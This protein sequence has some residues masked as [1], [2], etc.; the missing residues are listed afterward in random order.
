MTAVAVLQAR[1]DSRRLP[2]KALLPIAGLPV[3][4][5]AARRAANRGLDLIVATSDEGSDDPLADVLREAG[6]TV[7]RGSR[8]DVLGRLAAAIGAVGDD[9]PVI[10]LTADNVLPDGD[11]LREL[12]E[13]F[14]ARRL[15]YLCC[16][17]RSSGLPHG[18]S[19][20]IM[21]AGD[22]RLA[23]AEATAPADR[24]HVT[25]WIIRRHGPASFDRHRALG[26]G[27][28]RCTIDSL[29]DYLLIERLFRGI[30]DP[31][32]APALDLVRALAGD[33]VR[34]LAAAA[35]PRLVLGAAQLGQPYGIANRAGQPSPVEAC[36]IVRAALRSGVTHID[37]ARAYGTSEAA[38]GHALSEGW[39]GR[40]TV[41]TKLPSLADCPPDASRHMIE[42]QVD[43]HV[44]ASCRALGMDLLDVVLVHR[45]ADRTAWGG[46]A[47]QRLCRLRDD[48]VIGALGVSVC[49]PAELADLLDDPTV[50]HLQ[51]PFNLLDWRW[52]DSIPAIARARAQRPLTVH[53]R[54]A[55]LQGL[56]TSAEDAL[57]RR[58]HVP[59][60]AAIR[61]WLGE[62]TVATGRDGVAGLALG[63]VN[64]QPWLD[65]VV[66]GMESLA[67][68]ADNARHFAAPALS[69]EQIFEIDATRPRLAEASL[70][71]SQWKPA[72]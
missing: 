4:A 13:E 51:L 50:A 5:L 54:S 3:A 39:Q 2:G 8:D 7:F 12:E 22:L 72:I 69:P 56:L 43:A 57:W 35:V 71:P 44:F 18:F 47:W 11:F 55:L 36:A 59:D 46:A 63:Y 21:R 1:T 62:R 14:V 27:L 34:P 6:L 68:L 66:V 20:E 40:A 17:H 10:R 16:N 42:A 24:E 25:P 48:G 28:Y 26:M 60:P 23:A 37:T 41:I 53:A 64:A 31:V 61:A 52:S 70:D 29:D 49:A 38:I 33:P 32:A 45:A 58:A 65:G 15:S 30:A 67:Q 19:A 9:T